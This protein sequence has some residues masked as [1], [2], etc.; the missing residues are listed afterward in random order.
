MN[1][2]K[3]TTAVDLA[4][5]LE[6]RNVDGR[7]DYMIK[8]ARG[9][10]YHCF[11][12]DQNPEYADC[13]CP[14]TELYEHLSKFPELDD[15]KAAVADGVYDESPDEQDKAI[16]REWFKEDGEDGKRLMKAIGLD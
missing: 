8:R 1:E 11:K 10:G 16:M 5:E 3:K 7:Y 6:Q 15:I 14:K 12:H 9:N 13:I 2:Q 4:D